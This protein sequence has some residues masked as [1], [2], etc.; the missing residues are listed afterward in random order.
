MR[1]KLSFIG[2]FLPLVV[3][4]AVGYVVPVAANAV[5][6]ISNAASARIPRIPWLLL[7]S[8]ILSAFM[9]PPLYIRNALYCNH[10]NNVL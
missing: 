8:L 3:L 9:P 10:Q 5:H 1:K 4:M 6:A 2:S 7:I